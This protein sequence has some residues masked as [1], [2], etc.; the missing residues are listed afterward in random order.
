[1]KSLRGIATTVTQSMPWA[2]PVSTAET[3]ARPKLG[4]QLAADR[5]AQ[6]DTIAAPGSDLF[7]GRTHQRT[8]HVEDFSLIGNTA[9]RIQLDR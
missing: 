8:A 9:V 4:F 2:S 3:P 5:L 7:S 6:I 1:M